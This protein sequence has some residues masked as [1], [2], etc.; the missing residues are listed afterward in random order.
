MRR[1]AL[2]S[3]NKV[4]NYPSNPRIDALPEFFT[5]IVHQAAYPGPSLNKSR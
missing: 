5:L 3:D 1:L 2:Y 4:G